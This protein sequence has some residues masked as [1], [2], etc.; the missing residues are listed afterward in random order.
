M[1]ARREG[2]EHLDEIDT[3]YV[4]RGSGDRVWIQ[5]SRTVIRRCHAWALVAYICDHRWPAKS[6]YRWER[7]VSLRRYRRAH[8]RWVEKS[9]INIRADDFPKVLAAL[10]QVEDIEVGEPTCIERALDLSTGS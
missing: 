3:S 2:Y 6:D 9:A 10:T 4:P 5:R 1:G 8:G 7:N